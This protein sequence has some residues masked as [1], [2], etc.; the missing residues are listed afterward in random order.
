MIAAGKAVGGAVGRTLSRGKS[1][2]EEEDRAAAML[3]KVARGRQCRK[4]Q[5]Q[6][7]VAEMEHKIEDAL[8]SANGASKQPTPSIAS[9]LALVPERAGSARALDNWKHASVAAHALVTAVRLDEEAAQHAKEEADEAEAIAAAAM[10]EMSQAEKRIRLFPTDGLASSVYDKAKKKAE[11]AASLAKSMRSV[12]ARG[13]R[14]AAT[15]T[16]RVLNAVPNLG[17]IAFKANKSIALDLFGALLRGLAPA[18]RTG[19]G[20]TLAELN[21]K[22]AI[23]LDPFGLY[24]LHV[25]RPSVDLTRRC[26]PTRLDNT[27]VALKS[28]QDDKDKQSSMGSMSKLLPDFGSMG[29]MGKLLPDIV[30]PDK[31]IKEGL[32][33][34][35]SVFAGSNWENIVR[36]LEVRVHKA[37]KAPP[38]TNM[39]GAEWGVLRDSLKEALLGDDAAGSTETVE[40]PS[41]G[42]NGGSSSSR[43]PPPP[44]PGRSSSGGINGKEHRHPTHPEAMTFPEEWEG[45][46]AEVVRLDLVL[47]LATRFD[48]ENDRVYV[49]VKGSCVLPGFTF[50]LA[51]FVMRARVRVWWHLRKGHLKIAFLDGANTHFKSFAEFGS[52]CQRPVAD[53]LGATSRLMRLVLSRFSVEHPLEIDLAKDAAKEAKEKAKLQKQ[54]LGKNG[55]KP[56]PVEPRKAEIRWTS[57]L[58]GN[59]YRVPLQEEDEKAKK[60]PEK[61]KNGDSPRKK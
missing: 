2:K 53:T 34:V 24:S 10:R 15:T 30:S 1:K 57:G 60:E 47:D 26:D 29:S 44:S 27:I 13:A 35:A 46:A 54:Q 32:A 19:I 25:L 36:R 21:E 23:P 40:E 42:A 45:E 58:T 55:V 12:S 38:L 31:M 16:A 20:R 50:G 48:W 18:I 39:L 61:A 3:Q 11:K 56:P 6:A 5:Q 59:T 8:K 41:E 28:A 51:A 33:S 17:A 52:S 4:V 7:E 37:G 14:V 22:G 9:A 43:A 49:H